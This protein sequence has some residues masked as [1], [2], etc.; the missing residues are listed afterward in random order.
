MKA[1]EGDFTSHV[2]GIPCRIR[3]GHCEP[4]IPARISGPPEY[5]YPAEGGEIEFDI[6]DRRGRLAPWLAS[7]MSVK[8]KDRIEEE[9][10]AYMLPAAF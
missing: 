4:Y 5:C 1:I 6:L 7:K 2:A 8:D 10:M 9:V 3:I